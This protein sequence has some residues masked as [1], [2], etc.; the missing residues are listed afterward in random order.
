M[1]TVVVPSQI[2]ETPPSS[3]LNTSTKNC[4]AGLVCEKGGESTF[5]RK[6]DE[7]MIQTCEPLSLRSHSSISSTSEWRSD[8]PSLEGRALNNILR[9]TDT[10]N[11]ATAHCATARATSCRMRASAR[12]IETGTANSDS[13]RRSRRK[14]PGPL[15]MAMQGRLGRLRAGKDRARKWL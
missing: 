7:M 9:H 13:T 11:G 14:V 5:T 1:V 3:K 15:N 6:E 10:T 4:A 8:F 2:P 12:E